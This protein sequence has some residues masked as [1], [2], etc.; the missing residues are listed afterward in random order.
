MKNYRPALQKYSFAYFPE[1]LQ[2]TCLHV[3][4]PVHSMD[5]RCYSTCSIPEVYW[6]SLRSRMQDHRS[7]G[8]TVFHVILWPYCRASLAIEKIQSQSCLRGIESWHW[9]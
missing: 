7:R 4:S 3:Q 1:V 9:V 2:M 5:P 8:E 6:Y